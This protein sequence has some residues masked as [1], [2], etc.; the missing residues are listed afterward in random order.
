MVP[1]YWYRVEPN[2]VSI[3]AL[4]IGGADQLRFT[5]QQV[6]TQLYANEGRN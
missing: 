6:Q 1:Q 3:N 2:V 5:D 4:I